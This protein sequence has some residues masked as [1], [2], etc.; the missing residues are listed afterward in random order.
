MIDIGLDLMIYLIITG[1]FVGI[2]SAMVGIGG[3]LVM[4]PILIF[5]YGLDITTASAIN[6]LVIVA[7]SMAGGFTFWKQNRIDVRTGLFF[8]VISVPSAILGAFIGENLD[9]SFLKIAFGLIM[10]LVA[11]QKI[12]SL[13]YN[14]FS[15]PERSE[16]DTKNQ[17]IQG[18]RYRILPSSNEKRYLIDDEGVVFN[19]KIPFRKMLVG[20]FLGGFVAGLLGLGGGVIFVPVL[21]GGGI[22]THI[23]T[24]TSTFIIIF[25]SSA[26]SI[27]RI[28]GSNI[29]YEYV[30]L[31]AIGTIAGARLGA[32][33]IRRL[34]SENILT[35]FFIIVLIVG[36]RT[37]FEGL[38]TF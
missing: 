22:P 15:K 7:T 13:I 11:L 9:A 18:T 10:I 4:V 31:L 25:T 1:F 14:R 37:L 32:L 20:A 28:L 16:Q 12:I 5:F 29:I 6:T 27:V 17:I 38:S 3:G 30:L 23:A 2:L 8:A 26:S 24:A 33:K 21:L 34:S 35:V 36:I 19:Y